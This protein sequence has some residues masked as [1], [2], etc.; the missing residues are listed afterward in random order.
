MEMGE[1]SFV[2][3]ALPEITATSCSLFNTDVNIPKLLHMI[4][5]VQKWCVQN[6]VTSKLQYY[7]Y[8]IIQYEDSAKHIY[9]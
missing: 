1:L 2:Q 9:K 3:P 4:N 7:Q 8:E 5:V 6:S